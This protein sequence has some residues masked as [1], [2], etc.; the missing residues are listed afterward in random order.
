MKIGIIA[1]ME[2]EI[3]LLKMRLPVGTKERICKKEFYKA[4]K[5]KL[6]LILVCSGQ[7]KTNASIFTQILIQEYHPD[8]VLNIGVCGGITAA[9]KL[10]DLYIGEQYCHYDIRKKQSV[11]KYPYQLYF[12]AQSNIVAELIKLEP[13]LKV[14]IFGT[15][16][17]FVSDKAQKNKLI[18]ELAIDCV[19]MESASIA[20]CCYVNEIP[21]ASLRCVCDQADEFAVCTTE[22]LQ[23]QAMRKVFCSL[24]KYLDFLSIKNALKE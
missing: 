6:E 3:N 21:F 13:Q 11:H 18:Q 24:D 16:E 19:D 17:G 14:G 2:L 15:G 9:T 12:K 20:Q 5:D 23:E 1:A 10:F 8:F 22:A 4:Q 7:G